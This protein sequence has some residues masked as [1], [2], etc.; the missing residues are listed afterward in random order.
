[1]LLFLS[2]L[3]TF[4]WCAFSW[5]CSWYLSYMA[6]KHIVFFLKKLE[7]RRLTS[8]TIYLL[9]TV[10]PLNIGHLRIFTFGTTRFVRYSWHVHFLGCPLLGSFS[11]SLSTPLPC[12]L[13]AVCFLNLSC[14]K[15]FPES[16]AKSDFEAHCYKSL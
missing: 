8:A 2:I 10:K 4:F 1:M 12:V 3:V 11:V 16:L 13:V 6:R 14:I 15:I 5:Q 9:I 7:P